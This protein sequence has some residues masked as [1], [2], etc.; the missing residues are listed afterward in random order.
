MADPAK[1]VGV[2]MATAR[3]PRNDLEHIPGLL[4]RLGEDVTELL[5]T[6]LSLLK[7]EV[8]E[9]VQA[10]V[11]GGVMIAIG[12]VIAAIGFALLNIAVAFA[13]S[14]LFEQTQ[15][16]QPARYAAGFVIT[17]G[18]YLLIGGIIVLAMKSRLAKQDMV[19][20]R[21]IDELRKD[22]QWLK[23]EL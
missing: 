10:Y 17:G 15:L 22:K 1:G 14:I 4:S 19:P 6:K 9:D 23:N 2:A 12:G 11:R 18:A 7:V 16:S 21:S 13:V 5:D 20:N 8:K 3:E